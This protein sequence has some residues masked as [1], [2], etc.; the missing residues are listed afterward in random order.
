MS[1][2]I[3][4]VLGLAEAKNVIDVSILSLNVHGGAYFW[5]LNTQRSFIKK[6]LKVLFLRS[7][8]E[9]PRNSRQSE[10]HQLLL[11]IWQNQRNTLKTD[12]HIL[13]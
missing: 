2:L 12:K 13:S 4:H 11:M 8:Q 7:H 10:L 9:A 3:L 5:V 1:L 6:E